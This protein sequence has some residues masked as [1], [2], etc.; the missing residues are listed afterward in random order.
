MYI[1]RVAT[2]LNLAGH[3]SDPEVNFID[4]SSR[5]CHN[6]CTDLN[7]RRSTILLPAATRLQNPFSQHAWCI[8]QDRETCSTTRYTDP[9]RAMSCHLIEQGP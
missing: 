6:Y 5:C 3:S 8:Q 9:I 2:P 4:Q 7:S 1:S